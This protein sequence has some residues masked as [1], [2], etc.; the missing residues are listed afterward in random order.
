M[1]TFCYY[2]CA[3][4]GNGTSGLVFHFGGFNLQLIG[5]LRGA[6]KKMAPEKNLNL[7]GAAGDQ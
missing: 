7:D 6:S 5:G 2:L 1:Q 4:L 3:L